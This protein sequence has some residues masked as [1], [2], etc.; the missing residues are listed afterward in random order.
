MSSSKSALKSSRPHSVSEK[1]KKFRFN[2][3]VRTL[4]DS[5]EDVDLKGMVKN[6]EN[7]P[8]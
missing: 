5:P 4:S 2:Q 7:Q 3:I 1:I 6:Q 8:R